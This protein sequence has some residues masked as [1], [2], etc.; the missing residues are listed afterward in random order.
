MMEICKVPTMRLKGM[1]KHDT[2]NVHEDGES[3]L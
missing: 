2:P 1:N 3:Y